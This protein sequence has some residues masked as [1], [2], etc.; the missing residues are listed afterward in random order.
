MNYCVYCGKVATEIN[1]KEEGR[2]ELPVCNKHWDAPSSL[3]K[4]PE[5]Y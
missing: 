3:N 2:I 1:Y 5:D 4:G